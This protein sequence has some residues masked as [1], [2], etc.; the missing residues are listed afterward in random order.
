M[1]ATQAQGETVLGIV[2][3]NLSAFDIPGAPASVT[4]HTTQ[5]PSGEYL[6]VVTGGTFATMKADASSSPIVLGDKLTLSANPGYAR[7]L[8]PNEQ[9]PIIAVAIQPLTSGTGQIAV[10]VVSGQME[11]QQVTPDAQSTVPAPSNDGDQPSSVSQ[12]DSS[13]ADSSSTDTSGDLPQSAAG[14]NSSDNQQIVVPV[15]TST[16]T[17]SSSSQ[18]DSS[19]SATQISPEVLGASS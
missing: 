6:D 13:N 9:M 12:S 8:Q 19:S 14:T 11:T 5:V 4:T 3:R 10:Y 16:D 1:S 7:K 2:D 18:I 15:D 17:S